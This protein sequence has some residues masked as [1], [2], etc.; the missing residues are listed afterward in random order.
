[1]G[2]SV[3]CKVWVH[4]IIGDTQGNNRWVGH[5]GGTG[6][7]KCPYRDC[8][9]PFDKMEESKPRCQYI[10]RK[11]VE[12]AIKMNRKDVLHRLSKHPLEIAWH[13]DWVPLSDL[14][15]GVYKMVPPELLH[16]TM[17]GITE[18]IFQLMKEMIEEYAEGKEL[19]DTI[20]IIHRKLHFDKNRHSERDLPSSAA[21]TALFQLTQVG[22]T[23]RKG[24]LF[25]LLCMSHTA[26]IRTRLSLV[27]MSR[28]ISLHEFQS[29]LKLYL[30]MEEWFHSVN[31]KDQVENSRHLVGYV[32]G[33]I[34]KVFPRGT[35]ARNQ[36]WNIPKMHGLT[37]MQTYMVQFGS[38][39]NFYGGPGETFHKKFVKDTGNNTQGR[40]DSFSSQCATRYYESML[41]SFSKSNKDMME[42]KKYK[43]TSSEMYS[44]G[45]KY[46][47]KFFV[48]LPSGIAT[49]ADKD[50][51]H[52]EFSLKKI[53]SSVL[54]EYL[55]SNNYAFKRSIAGYSCCKTILNETE[56]KFRCTEDYM[57][58]KWFDWCMVK[59]QDD[60]QT[61]YTHPAQI[62]G[63][64]QLDDKE[65]DME[66]GV[67]AVV[68]TSETSISYEDISAQFIV[69]F[70]L[71]QDR[72]NDL[73]VVPVYSIVHP[74]YV[75]KNEG[76]LVGEYFC[77]IPR[78]HWAEYFGRKVNLMK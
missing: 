16:T 59:F 72:E 32:I 65:S 35:S 52:V 75:F 23:E 10:T 17:E 36:G 47:G 29:C 60:D 77:S 56:V 45:R 66:D 37:K 11:Q 50:K 34:K 14:I 41:F 20:E 43:L 49:P 6:R 1:M 70:E 54:D 18:Y 2:K 22:A 57:G 71:G 58:E 62:L 53:T 78:R 69:S 28:G 44:E 51:K 64:F 55:D 21:R 63:F 74:L 38:G 3:V 7:L 19:L 13:E 48:D 42:S 40:A 27:L 39:S 9:C 12:K 61:T 5:Y 25:L 8:M 73:C 26:A 15:H 24:N 4:F 67:F 68:H 31:V 76:G 33:L 30:A 46:E